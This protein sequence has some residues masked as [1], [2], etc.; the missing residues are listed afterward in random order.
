MAYTSKQTQ[1][2]CVSAGH[3]SCRTVLIWH[4]GCRIRW[5]LCRGGEEHKEVRNGKGKQKSV[6]ML[7][8][9]VQLRP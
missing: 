5:G 1:P 4:Y 3:N 8:G 6:M 2:L 7:M 9:E